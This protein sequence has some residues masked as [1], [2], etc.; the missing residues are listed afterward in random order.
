MIGDGYCLSRCYVEGKLCGINQFYKAPSNF[1]EC[2]LAC[3]KESVCSGFTITDSTYNNP[4]ECTVYGNI[5]SSNVA[6][7]ANH[8]NW[9]AYPIHTYG[10][11]GFDVHSSTGNSGAKCYKRQHTPYNGEFFSRYDLL[12]LLS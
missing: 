7:W 9:S 1:D 12:K 11:V 5:S 10:F 6:I 2:K 8:N 4:N 3:E